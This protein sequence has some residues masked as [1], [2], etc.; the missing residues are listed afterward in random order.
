MLAGLV[1]IEYFV[2]VKAFIDIRPETDI[3]VR[4]LARQV[5][6]VTSIRQMILGAACWNR[7]CAALITSLVHRS[8]SLSRYSKSWQ[9]MY[10][11]SLTNGVYFA[12]FNNLFTGTY[13][14]ELAWV[15]LH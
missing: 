1:I 15:S 14:N 12:P 4:P 11:D 10:A 8:P 3:H 9:I 13:F 7:G 5:L 6:C 2:K